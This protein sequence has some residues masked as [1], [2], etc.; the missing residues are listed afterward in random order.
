MAVKDALYI[1]LCGINVILYD[2]L[3]RANSH[4]ERREM[5]NVG[6]FAKRLYYIDFKVFMPT[7]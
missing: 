1:M 6:G 4:C 2:I 5:S 7:G 3:C